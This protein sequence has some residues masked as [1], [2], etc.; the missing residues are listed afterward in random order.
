MTTA[1][2]LLTW[3]NEK[4]SGDLKQSNKWGMILT[5]LDGEAMSKN[6]A[7]EF[8]TGSKDLCEGGG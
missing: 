4:K 5:L 6:Q 8:G 7:K 2:H 3:A 1:I